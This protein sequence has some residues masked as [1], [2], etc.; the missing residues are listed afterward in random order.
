MSIELV[1]FTDFS[2]RLCINT[3][4]PQAC[5]FSK[6]KTDE[7]LSVP[8]SPGFTAAHV[9]IGMGAGWSQQSGFR[10]SR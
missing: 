7:K 9:D 4:G 8:F 5:I 1:L 6:E 2:Q 3:P 10:V